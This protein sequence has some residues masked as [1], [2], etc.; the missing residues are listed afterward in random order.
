MTEKERLD[1]LCSLAPCIAV[2]DMAD[3]HLA[4]K[5]SHLGL[6][7]DL[8]HETVSLYPMKTA[9][10]TYSNDT[11]ALLTSVLK[12]MQ[13]IIS[14]ACSIINTIDSK[15]TALVVELVISVFITITH[16]FV[17]YYCQ[18]F[19]TEICYR[20]IKERLLEAL[21]HDVLEEVALETLGM[22]HLAKNLSVLADDT[23]DCIV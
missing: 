12:S 18:L 19:S 7:E 2:A 16:F 4:W 8:C 14:K 15:N 11:A 1:I 5:K 3:C 13:A 20:I 23:L 9:V 6:V 17:L 22:S 21:V 10:W